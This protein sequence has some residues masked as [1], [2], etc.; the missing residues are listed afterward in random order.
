MLKE[1]NLMRSV[2][3]AAAWSAL[4][5]VVAALFVVACNYP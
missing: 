1:R 3:V 5:A 2:T 4:A